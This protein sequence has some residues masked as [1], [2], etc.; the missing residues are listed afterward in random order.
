[1]DI[2]S[3]FADKVERIYVKQREGN[4]VQGISVMKQGE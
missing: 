4:N 1:M 2:R 3:R